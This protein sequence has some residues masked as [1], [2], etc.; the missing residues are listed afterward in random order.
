MLL[1]LFAIAMLQQVVPLHTP[2]RHTNAKY[3][4]QLYEPD[5]NFSCSGALHAPS[6]KGDLL[7]IT[8]RTLT[9]PANTSVRI[10]TGETLQADQP[11]RRRMFWEQNFYTVTK[12]GSVSAS[13]T[14]CYQFKIEEY[15]PDVM[16]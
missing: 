4:V 9:E 13:T 5:S 3:L 2:E 10:S 14:G 6:A 11:V 7:K 12:G 8:V 15:L 16:K 1:T